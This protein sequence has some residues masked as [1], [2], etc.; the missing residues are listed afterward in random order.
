MNK[1]GE[2]LVSRDRICSLQLSIA[3]SIQKQLP[4]K[5]GDALKYCD[6]ISEDDYLKALAL[7]N[8]IEVFD[9]KNH[10][11]I[12]CKNL[13]LDDILEERCIKTQDCKNNKIFLLEEI[14]IPLMMRLKLSDASVKFLLIKKKDFSTFIQIHF[15][16]Q[17]LDNA[18]NLLVN[19]NQ[20]ASARFIS[21]NKIFLYLYFLIFLLFK[22][23]FLFLLHNIANILLS[24]LQ[25]NFKAFL[26]IG[27]FLSDKKIPNECLNELDL[28]I[29]SIM[30]PLYKEANK[31]S[32]IVKNICNI[33]Y[34][35]DKLDVKI[36]IEEDD[37]ETRKAFSVLELPSHFDIILV[38]FS[39]PRTKPKAMNYALQLVR[40]KYLAIY[41]AEDRPEPLQLQKAVRA[42]RRL[43][44][45]CVCLQSR[46]QFYNSHENLLTRFLSLEYNIWFRHLL[47]GLD[48]FQIPIPLGGTSNHF[49][50]ES[51]RALFAWDPY[52]VT[53]DADLGIRI[54]IHGYKSHMLDSWTEEESLVDIRAW[55]FQRVRWIKGFIKTYII[56]IKNRP[57]N[58]IK[59]DL[60]THCF[61]FLPIYNFVVLPWLICFGLYYYQ[62]DWLRILFHQALIQ[63][64]IFYYLA[65]SYVIF[66]NYTKGANTSIYDFIAIL[67]LPFYFF[68]HTI[69]SYI[70]IFEL[71][72]DPFK[73]N[74][75]IHGTSKLN[76]L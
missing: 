18:I 33:N 11:L 3:L 8:K 43:P 20:R 44:E 9:F 61:I 28:P 36:I 13:N 67:L 26:M 57:N 72:R 42:F 41:D 63:S 30:I 39:L 25:T 22:V 5:I 32:D 46:L 1:F 16:D 4:F 52:N 64:C 71:L 58:S 55:F 23:H 40:G 66:K 65:S 50:V 73:W 14:N 53:E 19:K 51:L 49:K 56:Y 76:D 35:K 60:A 59:K 34:P 17:L 38:P 74:K 45:E 2:I 31:A 37:L 10:N 15:S 24:F 68:L 62:V 29:Y 69:A 70:A 7:Q 47:Q 54:G 21:Y 12:P 48:Y 6:W 27:S 75:T